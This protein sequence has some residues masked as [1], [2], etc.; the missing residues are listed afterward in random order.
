MRVFASH[1]YARRCNNGWQLRDARISVCVESW[2][3]DFSARVGKE[4]HD[5]CSVDFCDDDLSLG[6][7]GWRGHLLSRSRSQRRADD[8]SAARLFVVFAYVRFADPS[9]CQPLSSDRARLSG[10]GHSEAPRPDRYA[11]IFDH[12]AVTANA[13]SSSSAST[14]MFFICRTM[15]VRSVFGSC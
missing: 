9:A 13:L 7:C 15:A 5:D 8:R 1:A 3:A 12:L 14:A 4:R 2:R 11:Y 10:F 6:R